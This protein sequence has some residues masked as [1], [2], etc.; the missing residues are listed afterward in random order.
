[1][2]YFA[3]FRKGFQRMMAY[4]SATL[5][6][7]ATNF[8]FGLLRAYLFIA[9]FKASGQVSIGG[10]SLRDTITFTALT[11][12]LGS[13]LGIINWW[14]EVG[15]TIESG[16]IITDLT[17]PFHFFGF[18][19]SRDFGRMAFQLIFRGAP[20]MLVFPLFF[21]LTWP[22][23]VVQW[24]LFSLSLLMAMI[25]AFCWLFWQNCLSFWF[26]N[27]KGFSRFAWLAAAFFSGFLV[28]ISFFPDWLKAI[29]L[30]TPLPSMINTPIEIYLG[31]AQGPA[32]WEALGRQLFWVIAFILICE[33]T[34]RAGRKRLV[35]QGG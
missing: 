30:W 16:E 2:L 10:F 25:I 22:A 12:A 21:E 11:Q 13:T 26:V 27:A 31:V 28:P 9:V 34:F 19:L 17:K 8:F 23:S 1:M 32:L 14:W 18:W 24:L 15:K 4:R 7:I 33:W 3:L 29:T 6:G 20:I 5:A 35:I